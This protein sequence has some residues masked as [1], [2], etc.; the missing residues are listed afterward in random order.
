MSK[1]IIKVN[2]LSKLYRIGAVERGYKTFREAIIDWLSAPVKNFARLQ[3]LTKFKDRKFLNEK[4]EKDV[5]W[6]LKDVSFEINEGDVLGIIG[7]NGAGKTTL[8]KVLSHITEPT[9]GFI[10]IYGR[11]SSL[12]EIGVGFHPE[13]TGRENIFLNGA[14]L[15][16][17]R[18]E[19]KSKFDEIVSFAEIEKFIDTPLKRYS[20][21][22]YVRLAFAIA[23]HLEPEIML[24]DEVLAVGD[25]AFQKKCLGK[26]EEVAKGGRTVLFVSHNMQAIASLCNQCIHLEDGKIVN[27]GSVSVVIANYLKSLELVSDD[28]VISDKMRYYK[29]IQERNVLR[30]TNVYFMNSK[31]EKKR[32]L[33]YK[34]SFFVKIIFEVIRP[35]NEVRIGLDIYAL[36]GRRIS[37]TH[38]TDGSLKPLNLKKGCYSITVRVQNNLTPGCYIFGAGA[39]ELRSRCGLEHIPAVGEFTVMD[40]SEDR[41]HI[42]DPWNVGLVNMQAEW[43]DIAVL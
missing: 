24:V 15:G 31:C 4:V 20:S 6:A 26:M 12:L 36:D 18:H 27:R 16:M 5:I 9:S 34:E 19:I 7:R 1:P 35:I 42:Y 43:S 17:R 22:M 2:N 33:F 30:I 41:K 38:H 37:T 11:A 39:H 25:I 40:L 3:K 28:E 29:Y 10:E 21:G 32:V 14:I 23:A 8:L 13:L